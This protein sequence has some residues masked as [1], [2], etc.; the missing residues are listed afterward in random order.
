[1]TDPTSTITKVCPM[2]VE[3]TNRGER[4]YDLLAAAEGADHLRQRARS[5]NVAALICM[6]LLYCES[7]NPRKRSPCTST[8]RGHRDLG[9]G[10]LR[11]HAVH[12][13]ADCHLCIGQAASMGSLLL[14][15]APPACATRC[16]TPASWCTSLPA[17]S[18]QASDIERH[19]ED[20]IKMKRRLT[21]LRQAYQEEL[22]CNRQDTRSRLLHD[23]GSGQGVRPHRQGHQE[24]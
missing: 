1:M 13:L 11:H 16:P 8:P 15:P 5:T 10:D 18:G 3:Q 22:R 14:P 4:G 2:V 6:Q 24:P 20:I 17:A 19:A 9:H 23:G 7:E 21:R 12:P